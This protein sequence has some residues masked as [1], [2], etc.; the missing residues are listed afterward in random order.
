MDKLA[1]N[2]SVHPPAFDRNDVEGT[3]KKLCDYNI[4]LQEELQFLLLQ[5]AKQRQEG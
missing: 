4:K 3:V 5:L 2:I 1:V